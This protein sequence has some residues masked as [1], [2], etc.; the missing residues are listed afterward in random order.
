MKRMKRRVILKE[1]EKIIPILVVFVLLIA[2]FPIIENSKAYSIVDDTLNEAGMNAPQ[3]NAF[4]ASDRFWIFYMKKYGSYPNIDYRLVYKSSADGESWTGPTNV[5][6]AMDGFSFSVWFDGTYVHYASTKC[7]YNEPIKYRRGIPNSDGTITWSADEQVAVPGVSDG[8]YWAIN[9]A[10]DTSGHPWIGYQAALGTGTFPCVAKSASTDGTWASETGFPYTLREEGGDWQS[11]PMPLSSNAVLVLYGNKYGTLWA[12][13]YDGSW[14]DEIRVSPTWRTLDDYYGFSA[15]PYGSA[16]HAVYKDSNDHFI[17]TRYNPSENNFTEGEDLGAFDGAPVISIDQVTGDLYLFACFTNWPDGYVNYTRYHNNTWE[18]WQ[19]IMCLDVPNTGDI[20]KD[21][22]VSYVQ[23]FGGKLGVAVMTV[24]YNKI[25]FDYLNLSVPQPPGGSDVEIISAP[26]VMYANKYYHISVNVTYESGGY[27]DMEVIFDFD[28]QSVVYDY[29]LNKFSSES[30]MVIIDEVRSDGE[31][32]RID[33]LTIDLYVALT[34][35]FSEGSHTLTVTALNNSL[36]IGEDTANFQFENDLRI[37][38]PYVADDI[39]TPNQMVGLGGYLYYEGTSIVPEIKTGIT[40]K[41]KMGSWSWETSPIIQSNG[42]F[43]VWQY[44]PLSLGIYTYNMTVITAG[45][46]VSEEFE[47]RV[48]YLKVNSIEVDIANDTI[49]VEVVSAYDSSPYEGV[50]ISVAGKSA[51]TNESGVALVNMSSTYSVPYLAP[52]TLV[53]GPVPFASAANV[54]YQKV[55]ILTM[56]IRSE[57]RI[58]DTVWYSTAKRLEYR[59]EGTSAV[60]APGMWEPVRVMVNNQP[61]ENWTW[62]DEKDELIVYDTHSL[63]QVFWL[64]YTPGGG[65]GGGGGGGTPT[66]GPEPEPTPEPEPE[67]A[68]EP[69]PSP[70]NGG[71]EGSL[72]NTWNFLTTGEMTTTKAALWGLIAIFLILMV[73]RIF[74]RRD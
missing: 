37:A 14:S 16:V 42:Q 27:W 46:R 13:K 57:N 69:S 9:I 25:Y 39:V 52:V 22:L 64:D 55:Q 1:V 34:W 26:S 23:N 8:Y 72:L 59:T 21:T 31:M 62:D 58:T 30:S 43:E 7:D 18:D 73:S 19:T 70:N 24:T 33:T 47:V 36:E 35:A 17:Y 5:S 38:N 68:P 11:M 56:T 10:V 2:S 60:K 54:P 28:G 61:Y 44:A 63:I 45:G 29:N 40:V 50:A 12:K 71:G 4:Y 67:P 3:R 20:C 41:I 51:T 74:R 66:P 53:S 49:A 48:D 6:Y 65:T 32:S 15:V